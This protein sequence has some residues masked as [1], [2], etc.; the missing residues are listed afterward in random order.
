VI[1]IGGTVYLLRRFRIAAPIALSVALMADALAVL[2]GIIVA[3]PMLRLPEMRQRLPGGW[4]WSL[5]IIVIGLICLW[6]PVFTKL[7]NMALRW[8]NRP[9][10]DAIPHIRY[11]VA[12]VL[13]ITSQWIFWGIALWFAARSI[14]GEVAAAQ[15]PAMVFMIA[16]AN[17]IG[18]LAF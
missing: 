3:A 7:V 12:P 10:L 2:T 1:A 15:I 4:I 11:Y 18:Y 9:T 5:A 6:P 13:V 8:L 16:L 17:T 14:G